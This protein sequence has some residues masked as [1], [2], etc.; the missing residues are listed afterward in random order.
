MSDKL[1]E[2]ISSC[3]TKKQLTTVRSWLTNIGETNLL[4]YVDKL[5]RQHKDPHLLPERTILLLLIFKHFGELPLY[6]IVEKALINSEKEKP[7]FGYKFHRSG[8]GAYSKEFRRDLSLLELRRC[9]K[10]RFILNNEFWRLSAK[11]I[12]EVL[13]RS[14]EEVK[15]PIKH[16]QRYL[17]MEGT[18]VKKE[19]YK[20][21]DIESYCMGEQINI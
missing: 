11:G 8:F 7:L 13:R 12:Q 18:E 19:H 15:I 16:I 9:V 2:I 3:N 1:I 6:Y 17:D 21:H 4:G 14:T 5:I 20:L 10:W